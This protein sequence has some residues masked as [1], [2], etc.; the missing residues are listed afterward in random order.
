MD[1]F[2]EETR[3]ANEDHDQFG[4]SWSRDVHAYWLLLVFNLPLPQVE[5]GGVAFL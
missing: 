4:H 3:K 5:L 1:E 2:T